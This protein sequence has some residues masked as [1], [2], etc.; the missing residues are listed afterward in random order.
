MPITAATARN[1]A[2]SQATRGGSLAVLVRRAAGGGIYREALPLANEFRVLQAAFA[3]GVKVPRPYGYFAD[4][5]GRDAF[6]MERLQGETVG[7]RIVQK[8]ELAGVRA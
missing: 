5:A 2:R 7:R 8:P 4:L 6:A 1:S 3:A